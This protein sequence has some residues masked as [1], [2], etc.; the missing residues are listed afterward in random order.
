[1]VALASYA[2]LFVNVNNRQW[3]PDAIQF[4]NSAI[5]PTPSYYTQELFMKYTG[6]YVLQS[7]NSDLPS[8]LSSVSTYDNV[9][10]NIYIA[11]VNFS[12]NA[13]QISIY[14]NNNDDDERN[15]VILLFLTP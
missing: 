14:N 6:S 13:T 15:K 9:T 4:N 12:P 11:V 8:G 1:M 3:N 7:F 10:G 2:P 5:A